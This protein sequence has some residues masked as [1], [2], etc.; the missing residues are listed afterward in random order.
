MAE[1]HKLSQSVINKIAAGEVIE[2][3]ASVVKELMENAVDAKSTRIDVYVDKGGS[4]L[5]RVVDN[6]QGITSE[7]LNLAVAPHATSKI[8]EADD[9]F[10]VSTMGFRGEALASIAEISRFRIKS[11]TPDSAEGASMEVLGGQQSEVVPCGCPVGTTVEV[12]NIFCNTPVRKK[13]LKSVSTEFGYVSEQFYRIALPYPQT[14]FTL[15]HNGKQMANLPATGSMQQRIADVF[16]RE[17]AENLIWVQSKVEGISISGYVAHPSQ[18]R[19]N[20]KSQYLFLNGRFIRDKSLQH[21]LQEAYRGLITVGRFPI[22]F[23]FLELPFD[24]VDVNVHPTKLEVRFQDSARL[25]SVLLSSIRQKFLTSDM[26]SRVNFPSTE[27]GN[28]NNPQY[29]SQFNNPAVMPEDDFTDSPAVPRPPEGGAGPVESLDYP[30]VKYTEFTQ[31]EKGNQS[32]AAPMAAFNPNGKANSAASAAPMAAFNS[33]NGIEHKDLIAQSDYL[34]GEQFSNQTN[35]NPARQD[36]G[37]TEEQ[38]YTRPPMPT[39]RFGQPSNT[40]SVEEYRNIGSGKVP[41][42]KPFE[43]SSFASRPVS[44]GA[45]MASTED[46]EGKETQ[47]KSGT[48]DT[49]PVDKVAIPPGSAPAIQIHKRYIVTELPEGLAI[50]DQHALHERILY[51][52]IKK[53]VEAHAVVSQELLV[54]VPVDLTPQ[55]F[56]VVIQRRDDLQEIGLT[57]EPFGGQTVLLSAYP[58]ILKNHSPEILLRDVIDLLTNEAKKLERVE[59]LEEIYHRMACHAAVKAGAPMSPEEIQSL[60]EQM[61]ECDYVHHCPHGRPSILV[62]TQ[63][64]LDKQ[65]KRT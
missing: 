27:G 35:A 20:N 4:D 64:E 26:R 42:F 46:S 5:I 47:V 63:E 22:A 32:D 36:S 34:E 31:F 3:P 48:Q 23:L 45:A 18:T 52:Q 17:L 60:L 11:R 49:L 24:A 53:S 58:A 65:F 33:F 6:G 2:R 21:A 51:E 19:S 59:V 38:Q 43:D 25:Y 29:N 1:I 14:A 10:R 40:I 8:Q 54:P 30:G 61:N 13:Y 9:L 12:L 16:G 62:Y 39:A 41:E 7:Q 44:A 50:I 57:I 56:A 55:E 15:T 37:G 28:P